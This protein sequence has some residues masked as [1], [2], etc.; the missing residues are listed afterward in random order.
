MGLVFPHLSSF[1]INQNI[2]L[3]VSF[4]GGRDM[5]V[6]IQRSLHRQQR[7]RENSSIEAREWWGTQSFGWKLYP[8]SVG[9]VLWAQVASC[10]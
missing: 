1:D 7:V 5:T 3:A 9:A 4:L 10:F 8:C 2:V 6:H